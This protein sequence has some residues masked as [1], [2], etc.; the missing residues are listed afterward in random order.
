MGRINTTALKYPKW[1]TNLLS[2]IYSI[3]FYRKI[4]VLYFVSLAAVFIVPTGLLNI[5]LVVNLMQCFTNLIIVPWLRIARCF[6]DIQS[7]IPWLPCLKL[8]KL[9]LCIVTDTLCGLRRGCGE[10]YRVLLFRRASRPHL[11]FIVR[12]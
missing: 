3:L 1:E 6:A 2:V 5:S 7:V 8:Q 4:F 10:L 9:N 12:R 11:H